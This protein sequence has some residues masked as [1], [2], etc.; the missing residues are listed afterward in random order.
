MLTTCS[1]IKLN[2]RDLKEPK[3]TS[4]LFCISAFTL[5]DVAFGGAYS[6]KE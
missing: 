2:R 1:K 4:F 6:E 3:A 5:L